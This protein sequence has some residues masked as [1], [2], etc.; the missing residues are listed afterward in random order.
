MKYFN[1]DFKSHQPIAPTGKNI[2]AF[3][4][5]RQRVKFFWLSLIIFFTIV[6]TVVSIVFTFNESNLY[7]YGINSPNK[8][9]SALSKVPAPWELS[10]KNPQIYAPGSLPL[11][12][13]VIKKRKAEALRLKEKLA[14]KASRN[15]AIYK[16]TNPKVIYLTFDDGPTPNITPKVL[17]VLRKYDVRATFF[18]IGYM[19]KKNPAL[20]KRIDAE[21]HTVANHG[22]SH[23][24][25]KIYASPK[26]QLADV[27]KCQKVLKRILG[28]EYKYKIY[29]FPG[30]GL[31]KGFAKYKANLRKN[32]YYYFDWNML[33]NDAGGT[34]SKKKQIR[35][36]VRDLKAKGNII[37]LMH[38]S[39]I[40]Y[41]TPKALP[42][43]IRKYKK[44]GYEFRTLD[45]FCYPALD[46]TEDSAPI[47][48]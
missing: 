36:S 11:P 12:V 39:A 1:F 19:A 7:K 24:Y 30:G 45:E 9:I 44:R 17:A 35:N 13:D 10:V 47:I 41:T 5:N 2:L 26:K 34:K 25:A 37:L 8:V 14:Y 33:T 23:N 21:G 16:K 38:D 31:G 46:E 28:S 43:I 29:R 4:S 20:V 6:F 40:M 22:Y 18:L 3:W 15:N 48:Y 32:F 42:E 27:K